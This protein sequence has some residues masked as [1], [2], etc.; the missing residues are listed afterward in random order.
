M[1]ENGVPGDN[2]HH[3]VVITGMKHTISTYLKYLHIF[4]KPV[5]HIRHSHKRVRMKFPFLLLISMCI[6]RGMGSETQE[7]S[8]SYTG[9]PEC[10]Q[11]NGK[12]LL[13]RVLE[14][15]QAMSSISCARQCNRNRLCK[16]F[17][18]NMRNGSCQ[19]NWDI[20]RGCN[21]L[22]DL[23]GYRYFEKVSVANCTVIRH[24]NEIK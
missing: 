22:S 7:I 3:P 17:N 9:R 16:S 1:E 12:L 18:H 15:I 14:T 23:P 6:E 8:I 19:L 2:H 4:I 13:H 24:H 5:P 10:H 11:E 21:A 20:A